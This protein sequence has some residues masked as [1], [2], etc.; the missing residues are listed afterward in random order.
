MAGAWSS[1]GEATPWIQP[2]WP[3]AVSISSVRPFD[4]SNQDDH[5]RAGMP[6]RMHASDAAPCGEAIEEG[7]HGG[8]HSTPDL[9]ARSRLQ[10][11]LDPAPSS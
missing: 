5:T 8:S 9:V 10:R 3:E 1:T 7:P 11:M 2:D 4:R 6:W